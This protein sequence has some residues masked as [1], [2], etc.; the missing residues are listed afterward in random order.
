MV[1]FEFSATFDAFWAAHR[2]IS[3]KSIDQSGPF[4][5]QYAHQTGLQH[6]LVGI[7]AAFS[8]F[9]SSTLI[10]GLGSNHNLLH[11]DAIFQE[12]RKSACTSIK[13]RGMKGAA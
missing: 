2:E 12:M 11:S 8:F 7:I 13:R 6:S 1:N 3:E 10:F 5:Q 4:S 9:T